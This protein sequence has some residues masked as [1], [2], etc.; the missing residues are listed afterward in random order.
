MDNILTLKALIYICLA[1]Y[2]VSLIFNAVRK[3][4]IYK[5][6]DYLLVILLGLFLL[7]SL[8]L[9]GT[10]L[11]WWDF[12]NPGIRA[13]LPRY[14]LLLFSGVLF[15]LTFT[16]FKNENPGWLWLIAL[17]GIALIAVVADIL[18]ILPGEANWGTSPEGYAQSILSTVI[19]A[20]G[21]GAF[22]VWTSIQVLQA[23]RTTDRRVVKQRTIYWTSAMVLYIGS[24]VLFLLDR[25]LLGSLLLLAAVI[26]LNYL[27]LTYRLPDLKNLGFQFAAYSL[28]GI[29][30]MLINALGF[31]ILERYFIGLSWY[32]PVFIGVFFSVIVLIFFLPIHKLVKGILLGILPSEKNRTLEIRSY[33]KTLSSILDIELLSKVTIEMICEALDVQKGTLFLVD[34]LEPEKDPPNWYLRAVEG[35]STTLPDLDFLPAHSPITKVLAEEKRPLTQSELEF[36]PKFQTIPENVMAWIRSLA[37]EAL[38]PIHTEDEWIGLF[39]LSQKSSGAS[40]SDDELEL[41][42]TVADQTSVALQNARLVA[43]LSK[44]DSQLRKA[45]A[46]EGTALDKVEQI[47]KSATD[48]ISIKAH[49]L[50]SPLTIVTGYSR[51]LAGDSSLMD[52][53]YY[54][55]LIRGIVS[56]T[57]RLEVIIENMIDTATIQ[58]KNLT[59]DTTPLSLYTMID[60]ICQDLR[61]NVQARKITLS[62]D[63]LG[64]IPPVYGDST[65]LKKVFEILI[66]YAMTHTPSGGK[67]TITGR[68]IPPRSE[69]LKWEG[70]EIVVCD[71]GIGIDSDAKDRFFQEYMNPMQVDFS[72]LD[73]IAAGEDKPGEELAI[74]RSVIEAHNGR[75]WVERLVKDADHLPGS[76]FHVVLP[77]EQQSYPTQPGQG[78]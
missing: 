33:S 63:N 64:E 47:K 16:V 24:S 17:L 50:R 48:I 60:G 46:S 1:V 76:E 37:V 71:T 42:S 77:L 68:H 44:I 11:S 30:I 2:C 40:F 65:A 34:R 38:V 53:A 56:G 67:I 75:I 66:N 51:L 9:L 27:V 6:A 78:S 5:I 12:M 14:G 59:I 28:A 54:G 58:P 35:T 18:A 39:A 19:Q 26:I 62:H 69:V 43:S 20:V 73:E 21:W 45:K 23:Y 15:A 61:G 7:I 13:H 4:R 25:A 36:I 74:V 52:D 49:E 3:L 57:D 72:L 31:L 70:A 29:T 22:V 32:K 8:I 41:L 10:E 55:E